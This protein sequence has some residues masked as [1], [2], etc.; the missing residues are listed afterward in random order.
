MEQNVI[1]QDKFKLE[2]KELI[3]YLITTKLT[4]AET[5]SIFTNKKEF[6]HMLRNIDAI[7]L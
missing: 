5:K 4:K 3:N 7:E 1:N 6:I 2:T